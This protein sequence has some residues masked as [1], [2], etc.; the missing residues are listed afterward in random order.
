MSKKDLAKF[1]P[2]K[3]KPGRSF[4]TTV[5]GQDGYHRCHFFHRDRDGEL[6]KTITRNHQTGLAELRA[7][8]K[9]KRAKPSQL[10]QMDFIKEAK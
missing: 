4:S 6:F 5:V 9:I 8:V 3:L 1:K 10:K 7:W 2:E